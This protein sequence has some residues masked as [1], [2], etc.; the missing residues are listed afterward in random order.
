M[1]QGPVEALKVAKQ[2]TNRIT[3][4]IIILTHKKS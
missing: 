2:I 4:R 3:Y 1:G